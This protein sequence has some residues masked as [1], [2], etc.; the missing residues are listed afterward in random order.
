MNNELKHYGVLGMKWGKRKAKT[1]HED[2]ARTHSKKKV[3]EMSDVE[4]RNRNNRLQ[5]EQQY[6]SLTKRTNYA[7]KAVKTFIAA[8]VTLVAIDKAAKTYSKYGKAALDKIGNY[9]VKGIDLSG[10]LTN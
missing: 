4:L 7:Q 9:V 1:V 2:Y 8:S 6:K 10:K 5:A 3:S